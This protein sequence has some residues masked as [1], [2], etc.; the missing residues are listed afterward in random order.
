MV[1][2]GNT[3]QVWC[4]HVDGLAQSCDNSIATALEIPD[5]RWVIDVYL[6]PT[7]RKYRQLPHVEYYVSDT[8]CRVS[9]TV[10]IISITYG[11]YMTWVNELI[12]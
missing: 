7:A 4:D 11:P 8:H 5:F 3:D 6:G 9:N 12:D 10:L 1:G 2:I